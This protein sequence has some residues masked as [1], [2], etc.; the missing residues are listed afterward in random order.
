MKYPCEIVRTGICLCP[1][2]HNST[3]EAEERAVDMKI[4]GAA[5]V[6]MLLFL[7]AVQAGAELGKEDAEHV[8][9]M[10]ADPLQT[11]LD[12]GMRGEEVQAMQRTMK[13]YGFK[14]YFGEWW[15]FSD[16]D[17]YEVE[18]TFIPTE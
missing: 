8:L 13:K 9:R 10:Q 11:M 15:H 4:K 3:R 17:T 6:L 16:V 12:I 14:P 7:L 18:K 1:F 2:V 5:V